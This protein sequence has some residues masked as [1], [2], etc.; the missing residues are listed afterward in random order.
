MRYYQFIQS[1]PN[2]IR[3]YK[4]Y[5]TT[6][7]DGNIVVKVIISQFFK[8]MLFEVELTDEEYDTLKE[9]GVFTFEDLPN[10]Y[11]ILKVEAEDGGIGRMMTGKDFQL[12][13]TN[14]R[15]EYHEQLFVVLRDGYNMHGEDALLN[16]NYCKFEL[17]EDN[18]EPTIAKGG[19]MFNGVVNEE[20]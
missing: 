7:E 14:L 11:E 18:T 8:E 17:I 9:K 16:C 12:E 15:G 19:L 5:K 3:T 6:F 13:G 1:E 10:S 20:N 2:A 4:V